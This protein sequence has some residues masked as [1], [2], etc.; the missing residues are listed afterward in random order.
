M[1]TLDCQVHH[2]KELKCSYMV[3]WLNLGEY[4]NDYLSGPMVRFCQRW[5]TKPKHVNHI[6]PVWHERL[7][8]R[9]YGFRYWSIFD[10]FEMALKCIH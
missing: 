2:D 7:L 5:F 9:F 3:S 6:T 4:G 1:S 10:F 8:E